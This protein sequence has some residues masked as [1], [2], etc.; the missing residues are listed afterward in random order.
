MPRAKPPK[1][2]SPI[3]ATISP[4]Q[5]AEHD[6]DRFTPGGTNFLTKDE[7]MSGIIPAPFL[8]EAR[9]LLDVQAHYSI[10]G[11][12]V[13]GGQLLALHIPRAGNEE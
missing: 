5:N 2:T 8:G 4:I 9:Y 11:E 10:S 13:Q 12:L 7:E 1:K 6:P 3:S